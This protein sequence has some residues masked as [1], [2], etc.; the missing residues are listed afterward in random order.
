M[1]GNIPVACYLCFG[2]D[3]DVKELE[4]AI[5]NLVKVENADI[6]Q[7][8]DMARLHIHHCQMVLVNTYP[9]PDQ[10]A[11]GAGNNV[12]D[13]P[14]TQVRFGIIMTHSVFF[15]S[16]CH[17]D[18][19]NPKYNNMAGFTTFAEP[20]MLLRVVFTCSCHL[21]YLQW[22][23]PSLPPYCLKRLSTWPRCTLTSN[24]P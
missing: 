5:V 7:K 16:Q 3:G 20:V 9:L 21:R 24:Q 14:L 22:C 13:S 2:S 1:F 18:R 8:Q 12:N 6:K 15:P 23:I 4:K 17:G 10:G 11:G 19:T